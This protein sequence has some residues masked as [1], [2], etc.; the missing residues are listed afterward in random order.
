MG[1]HS[2]S[3][4]NLT[5]L[6]GGGGTESMWIPNLTHTIV[7]EDCFM[8]VQE[9]VDNDNRKQYRIFSSFTPLPEIKHESPYFLYSHQGTSNGFPLRQAWYGT[10]VQGLKNGNSDSGE[11][12]GCAHPN[13]LSG[14]NGYSMFSLNNDTNLAYNPYLNS[15]SWERFPVWIALN[16]QDPSSYSIIGE[17][18]NIGITNS[19]T[20]DVVSDATKTIFMGSRYNTGYTETRIVM[21]WSGSSPG[22]GGSLRNGQNFSIDM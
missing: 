4:G 6:I 13:L 15:G 20:N 18:N 17:A 7:G 11:G 22:S 8:F 3:R 16:D 14:T 9:D 12:G 21:P 19:R 5:P 2:A 10:Q 1:A